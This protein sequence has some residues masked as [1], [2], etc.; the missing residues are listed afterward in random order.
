MQEM[1]HQNKE[2]KIG[3]RFNKKV[4]ETVQD[5]LEG[6]QELFVKNEE[7]RGREF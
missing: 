5:V 2:L 6:L 3:S 1:A 7:E 4:S